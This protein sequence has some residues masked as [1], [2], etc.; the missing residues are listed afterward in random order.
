[1]VHFLDTQ[2]EFCA[3]AGVDCFLATLSCVDEANALWS[4]SDCDKD[5]AVR[6]VNAIT[7]NLLDS[8]TYPQYGAFHFV[9]VAS[10]LSAMPNEYAGHNGPVLGLWTVCFPV[11][12]A[13]L[14]PPTSSPNP[15]NMNRIL[16]QWFAIF[17][18]LPE[19]GPR[20][21]DVGPSASVE[22]TQFT[23]AQLVGKCPATL[24]EDSA[25]SASVDLK[26][27]HAPTHPRAPPEQLGGTAVTSGARPRP[28]QSGGV[29]PFKH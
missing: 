1:M 21:F 3:R 13:H 10:L 24:S 27:R 29:S 26:A 19:A 25:P 12:S 7:A 18:A 4:W 20:V 23:E 6:D 16:V 11:P 17:N 9:D 22:T 8:T 28:P 15:T 14:P 2:Q 5:S